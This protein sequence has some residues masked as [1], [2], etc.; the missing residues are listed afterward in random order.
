MPLHDRQ[1]KPLKDLIRDYI[2]D[3]PEKK[4]LK[5]GMVLSLWPEIVGEAIAKQSHNLHFEG[6]KLIVNVSDTMWR[7]ELHMQRFAI[8][9]KL[10]EAV[11][12]DVVREIIVRA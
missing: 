4:K 1:P 6:D 11:R 9:K 3:F 2:R 8:M 12:E 7:Q 5:K 10:N